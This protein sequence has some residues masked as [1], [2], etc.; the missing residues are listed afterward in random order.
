M[1]TTV[2]VPVYNRPDSLVL[3]IRSLIRER[4]AVDMDILIVDDGS[5]D[6]TPDVIQSLADSHPEIRAVRRDNGGVTKA[7]NTGLDNL[8]DETAFVTFLDSDDTLAADRFATDMPILQA[9]PDIALTYGNMV[10]TTQIDPLTLRPVQGAAQKEITGIHLS[11]ALMRRSLITRIG[12]F[13]ETLIQAED[14]DYL[15]RIFETGTGF[16]QTSTICHY[17]L[18]HDGGMTQDFDLG[19]KYF[20][21]AVMKSLQRRKADPTRKLHKPTFDLMLPPEL[22]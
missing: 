4:N 22:I 16:V 14:T 18:R 8:H 2:I 15:L 21:R 10:A 20:A 13:D 11:C 3:A 1:K 9:Q 7:R 17:Y 5:T 19:R 12:R 6:Q